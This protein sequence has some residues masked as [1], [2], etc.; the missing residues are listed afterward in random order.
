[1]N[2]LIRDY[3]A[4]VPFLQELGF[5]AVRLLLSA[6]GGAGLF[7]AR[8]FGGLGSGGLHARA[9]DHR[10]PG[11]LIRAATARVSVPQLP[12]SEPVACARR[13][14]VE[15]VKCGE[16]LRSAA[17]TSEDRPWSPS[18]GSTAAGEQG[19]EQFLSGRWSI[20]QD[21]DRGASIFSTSAVP[22]QALPN[23]YTGVCAIFSA[24]LLNGNRPMILTRRRETKRGILPHRK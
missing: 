8:V 11:C 15:C 13:W 18:I 12:S 5:A 23:P 19:Q 2:K 6:Q 10:L 14:E 21:P 3:R 4:L 9:A 1:M 16:G 17:R 7:V 20:L 24:R 22:R